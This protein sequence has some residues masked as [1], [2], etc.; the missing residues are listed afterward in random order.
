MIKGLKEG[1]NIP[2]NRGIVTEDVRVLLW[3][4]CIVGEKPAFQGT[5]NFYLRILK[6][7]HYC[8]LLCSVCVTIVPIYGN[9]T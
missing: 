7:G 4:F 5:I 6:F 8:T 9:K 3:P 2:A 1:Q